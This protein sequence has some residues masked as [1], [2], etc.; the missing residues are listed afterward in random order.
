MSKKEQFIK[1]ALELFK[2]NGYENTTINMI[3]DKVGAAK[4]SFYYYFKS[5]EELLKA[6]MLGQKSFNMSE[7]ADILMSDKSFFEQYWELQ[8]PKVD[9]ALSC[10]AEIMRNLML[11]HI[12]DESGEHRKIEVS[13]IE[14]AK[15]A[16]EIKN[17]ASAEDLCASGAIIFLGMIALWVSVDGAFD[18][19][20]ALRSSLETGF[21]V[22]DKFSRGGGLY[23]I[24]SR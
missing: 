5:K 9:F 7:L 6:V 19:E 8:K 15:N 3:L 10:G 21:N 11:I 22:N 14:K 18:F 20:K 4:N 12:K 23:E 16:G 24:I 1:A 13:L 17:S 2:E